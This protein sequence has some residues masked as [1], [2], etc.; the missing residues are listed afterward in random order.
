MT[1]DELI[2]ELLDKAYYKDDSVEVVDTLGVSYEIE[3]VRVGDFNTIKLVI[4]K[5][6]TSE[7]LL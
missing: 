7:D 4:N 5:E 1:L 3:D 6:A 2:K